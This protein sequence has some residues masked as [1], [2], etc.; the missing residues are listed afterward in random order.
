MFL[1]RRAFGAFFIG[2]VSAVFAISFAAIVYQGELAAYLDRGIALT[3][4]GSIVV[5]ITGALTLTYRGAIIAPQDVPAILIAGA[6]GAFVARG[7]MPDETLFATTA[8]L[9]AVASLATGVTS[10]V[11]GHFRLAY[12]ARYVP[13]PVLAGFL[14]ATGLLLVQGG[15]GIALDGPHGAP[16]S[17]IETDTLIKWVPPMVAALGILI[18][19]RLS[20]SHFVLPLALIVAAVGFFM[21]YGALGLTGDDARAKGLML[22]PFQQGGFL[23]G[24]G[25]GLVAQADW[26]AI[27]AQVPVIVTIVAASLIGM[28][29]NA[30]GLELAVGRELDISREVRG[31]GLANVLSSLVGGLPSY[32]IVGE[33]ILANRLGLTNAWAGISSAAGCA[34]VLFFGAGL[35]AGLPVGLFA[36]VIAYLGVDLLYSWLWEMRKRLNL[37][38][39]AIVLLIPLVAVSFGFLAAIGLGLLAACAIF[40]YAYA[41]LDVIRRQTDLTSRRS[42]VERSEAA[43]QLLD[44]QGH[45]ARVVELHGY[46]FFGSSNDLR[47]R[48]KDALE[49]DAISLKWLVLDFALVSGLDVSTQRVLLRLAQDCAERDIRAVFTG[50]GAQDRAHIEAGLNAQGAEVLE[51]LD[52]A[53]EQIEDELTAQSP[54]LGDAQA[55]WDRLEDLLSHEGMGEIF[56]ELRL[57]PGDTLL[58]HGERSDDIYLLRSGKLSVSLPQLDGGAKVVAKVR[59][60]AVIGEMAHYAGAERSA[61]IMAQTAAELW[62]IDMSKLPELEAVD[63]TLAMAFHRLISA[64]LAK[65]LKRTT[66]LLADIGL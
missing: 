5:A 40:I 37:Q 54:D 11:I 62:C 48:L 28:T 41:K 29:L 64:N 39:Y 27:L 21:L 9:I 60:G 56:K 66:R 13:Y 36:A 12:V 38:D 4:M 44:R 34:I 25:P 7:N 52:T 49:R 20:R 1:A 33:S 55:I 23:A 26:P 19:T 63:P 17:W 45:V 15:I 18:A 14:A 57:A 65:R 2:L 59:A 16:G 3:L 22:G 58:R 6:T 51:H 46:L 42:V 31:A 32:H 10:Y 47:E 43:M 53:L 61:D 24:V 30:S 50:L 8:A 35:L